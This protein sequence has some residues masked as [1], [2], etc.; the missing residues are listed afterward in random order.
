MN[1]HVDAMKYLAELGAKCNEKDNVINVS[2]LYWFD[3][4][5]HSVKYVATYLNYYIVSIAVFRL[6]QHHFILLF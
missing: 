3:V 1:G 5:I 4:F 2:S 6:E